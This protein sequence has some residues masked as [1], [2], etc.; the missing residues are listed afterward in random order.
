MLHLGCLYLSHFLG[1][2]CRSHLQEFPSLTTVSNII[3]LIL[4]FLEPYFT[5]GS[6][7]LSSE[8]D[9]HVKTSD[10][11]KSEKSNV[12]NGEIAR[13]N[14]KGLVQRV[15]IKLLYPCETPEGVL[16]KYGDTKERSAILRRMIREA[17]SLIELVQHPNVVQ[18]IGSVKDDEYRM[19]LLMELCDKETLDDR[20]SKHAKIPEHSH[21]ELND[22]MYCK[23]VILHITQGI[24]HIHSKKIYH[25]D[26]KPS[27]ILFSLDG[28]KVKVSD[29]GHSKRALPEASS[30]TRTATDEFRP[31][32]TYNSTDPYQ[33]KVD[34]RSDVFSLGLVYFMILTKRG[35]HPFDGT[36]KNYRG[37][38]SLR[39][40]KMKDEPDTLR[41]EKSLYGLTGPDAGLAKDLIE[42]MLE[43][44]K[45]NRPCTNDILMHPYFWDMESICRF[46]SKAADTLLSREEFA[47]AMS[48]KFKKAML[49]DTPDRSGTSE[50]KRHDNCKIFRPDLYTGN[51][52]FAHQG[53][54]ITK[55][56]ETSFTRIL[57]SV[58][59]AMENYG[60]LTKA[61]KKLF[62]EYNNLRKT[63][64][65][66]DVEKSMIKCRGSSELNDLTL[67]RR[68]GNRAEWQELEKKYDD[69]GIKDLNA[70][71]TE[72]DKNT[73]RG[74]Y[75]RVKKAID[76]EIRGSEKSW[77]ACF[78][79]NYK[80]HHEQ[81]ENCV[82][83]RLFGDLEKVPGDDIFDLV[84]YVRYKLDDFST[85]KDF[86]DGK[87]AQYQEDVLNFV[88]A[89]VPELLPHLYKRMKDELKDYIKKFKYRNSCS[90]PG[91][92][93]S[94]KGINVVKPEGDSE[95]ESGI[96]AH[97]P[98]HFLHYNIHPALLV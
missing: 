8:R 71:V 77:K 55:E 35:E 50:D 17:R 45:T 84:R 48:E 70:M 53:E 22:R 47:D 5:E 60:D 65:Y 51:L 92:K 21:P 54:F 75:F 95:E 98:N 29:F 13:N 18:Y 34:D 94:S 82:Y 19:M 9:L 49:P 6:K 83:I 12:Y 14:T 27:N 78:K 89:C 69:F 68:S 59:D 62:D 64:D 43:Y 24:D 58:G 86:Y 52:T 4:S 93:G 76:E 15:A 61:A 96:P 23:A 30:T 85:F 57:K 88:A 38:R 72:E 7:E 37:E 87:E 91:L 40:Q 1:P 28:E 11:I 90:L 2:L 66:V 73:L 56:C 33:K 10:K 42:N 79:Q 25:R 16:L 32:E 26:I 36:G 39:I 97:V 80:S 44:E 41:K 3:I 20:I 67:T 81:C 46:Y 63:H 74:L 31:P